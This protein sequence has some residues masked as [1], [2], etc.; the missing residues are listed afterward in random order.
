M[1]GNNSTSSN[2]QGDSYYSGGGTGGEYDTPTPTTKKKEEKK[3]AVSEGIN[4]VE[5]ALGLTTV[6]NTPPPGQEWGSGD[7][8]TSTFAA[9]LT[10]DDKWH[11]GTEASQATDDY[12][13]SLGS[14]YA[15]VGNYFRKEGGN[16]VR[17]SNEEGERLY[18]EGDPNISRSILTTSK[19]NEVKYGV[20]EGAMG[21]GDPTGVM[22]S[23]PISMDMLQKQNKIKTAVQGAIGQVVPGVGGAIAKLGMAE[24]SAD[25]LQPGAAYQDY[26]QKFSAA[27]AGKKFTSAR[28]VLGVL[29][30]TGHKKKTLGE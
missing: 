22:T 18:A 8:P 23:T 6:P 21:S 5:T 10:G 30:L 27:Q 15:T 13:I 14:D 1:G 29:G 28:N 4:A 2:S 12:L 9:N 11:Y 19:G 16:F 3:K 24:S 17:I 20:S 7:S 25:L 26:K